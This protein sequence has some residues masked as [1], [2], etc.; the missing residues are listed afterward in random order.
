[1]AR[2]HRQFVFQLEPQRGI[3]CVIVGTKQHRAVV[4]E[5]V[6]GWQSRDAEQRRAQ[7]EGM[8]LAEMTDRPEAAAPAEEPLAE[9]E[10]APAEGEEAPAA[11]EGG[12]S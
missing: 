11:E 2:S 8:F 5:L 9:G 4:L 6:P 3:R 7:L 1:V 12:E 10:E